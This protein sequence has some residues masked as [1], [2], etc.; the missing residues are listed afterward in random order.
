MSLRTALLVLAFVPGIALIVLWAVTSGQTYLDFQRQADQGLLAE[1]AGN[2]SNIVYYNLQEER[3]LSAEV[4]AGQDGAA[5]ELARQRASTDKAVD[6][7]RTLSDDLSSAGGAPRQIREAVGEARTA[8]DRLPAQRTLVDSGDE[9]QQT[10]VYRYYTNLIAVDLELFTSLSQVDNGRITVLAQPLVDLFWTKEMI[11]RSDALLARGWGE[12]TLTT[13]EFRQVREAVEAQSFLGTVKVAPRLP[14]DERAM[15]QRI[16]GSAAWKDKTAVEE[17]VLGA[18]EPGAGGRIT[19]ADDRETWRGAVDALTPDLEE[20]LE[21]RTVL[22]NEQGKDSVM[23]LLFRMVLVTVVGLAAVLAVI[24]MTWRFTRGLRLR[25]GS[26]QE[27]AELLEAALPEV[28]ERLARGERIDVEAEAKAIPQHGAD[29]HGD[30]LTRLGSALNLARTSALRAAVQQADQHRGFE[31]LLQRIARRTQQLIGQQLKKLDEMERRHED[32]EVLDGLFDLDHLTARLRRYEENLV[33]LAGGT[34]HRRWR[35]PVALLDVMRAAQGEVQDYRRVVL[36]E[37][38]GHW[39]AAR[40]VG[41]VAHVLAELIENALTFS[42]PP[43]PVEVRAAEVSRGLAVEIEDRGLGMEEEA[44]A[45][46]NALMAGPQ[47]LDVLAHS[48]DIRLGLHVVARLTHQYGLRVEF[49]ASAF[50]GTRV[51]VLVP[52]ELTVPAPQRGPVAVP[53]PEPARDAGEPLPV[54]V[55]GRAM[56]D[57]TA[58]IPAASRD[59]R[60][61]HPAPAPAAPADFRSPDPE[62]SGTPPHSPDDAHAPGDDWPSQADVSHGSVPVHG[63]GGVSAPTDDWPSRADVSHGSV[64]AHGVEPVRPG[65]ADVPG[66]SRERGGE[67]GLTEDDAPLPRRVRQASLVDELRVDPAA[68]TPLPRRPPRWQDD[69]MLRPVPRRAGATIG[70]FQRR[71]RAAREGR[72][73]TPPES[74]APGHPMREEES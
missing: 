52:A 43:S 49:R 21:H 8:I 45:A 23:A 34:P 2:P 55:Q 62:V 59:P 16:T 68:G 32:P 71:S 46:A 15:W 7:F 65:G 11:S 40:A 53:A 3:R 29:R 37:E 28:V 13:G 38:G 67:S 66:G 61:P 42:R 48:D 12:G 58:L 51:V 6:V 41:P 10:A 9:D 74:S 24:W 57:V 20:L 17:R 73:P 72:T 50:G 25:I 60:P 14:A 47:R 18:G 44:L 63:A 19:L 30:E 69:P 35:K 64:P 1:K 5:E 27:Q 54:R 36:E 26:L 31:R 70:A 56:A 4:L 22:V 33:I 39:L